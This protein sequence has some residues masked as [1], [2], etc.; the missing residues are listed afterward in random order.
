MLS[1]IMFVR[2]VVKAGRKGKEFVPGWV[3]VAYW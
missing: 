3:Y 1:L 2:S